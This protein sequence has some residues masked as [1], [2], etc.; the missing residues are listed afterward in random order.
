M[1]DHA[2]AD[3]ILGGCGRS[4]LCRLATLGRI[5]PTLI[6]RG[7]PIK[8]AFRRKDFPS[9][10]ARFDFAWRSVRET[11][12][13][14]GI[15]ASDANS[16]YWRSRLQPDYALACQVASNAFDHH[17]G[18][19]STP[20]HAKSGAFPGEISAHGILELRR[21]ITARIL[22]T[23]PSGTEDDRHGPADSKSELAR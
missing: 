3:A 10:R 20:G 4:I 14:L 8:D 12:K 6:E 23:A 7:E 18:K 9:E 13:I 21:R 22:A 1:R 19:F 15:D 2:R 17:S 5:A 11:I 16:S